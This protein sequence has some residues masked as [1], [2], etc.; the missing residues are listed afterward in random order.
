M[1][2]V[3]S[4]FDIFKYFARGVFVLLRGSESGVFLL[5]L[6][7]ELLI[8]GLA[9]SVVLLFCGAGLVF[10]LCKEGL[11]VLRVFVHTTYL[12]LAALIWAFSHALLRFST[13]P[14]CCVMNS[15]QSK[16]R[17]ST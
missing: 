6:E 7:F 9:V 5:E 17:L 10:V 14:R 8:L 15:N 1:L 11:V 12:V 13:L 2:L 3:D 16:W 4:I